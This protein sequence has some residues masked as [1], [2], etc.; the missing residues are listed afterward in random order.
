MKRT[1]ENPP[2]EL[3]K[4]EKPVKKRAL[5][6]NDAKANFRSGLFDDSVLKEYTTKY[7]SSEP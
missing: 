5:P 6:Q 2:E 7:A 4:E 3:A 1:A